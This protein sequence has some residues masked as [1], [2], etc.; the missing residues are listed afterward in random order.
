M[1]GSA[2]RNGGGAAERER[3]LDELALHN[4]R[5]LRDAIACGAH[6]G[7]QASLERLMTNLGDL[8][9]RARERVVLENDDHVFT[10]EDLLPICERLDA[11]FVHD[12]HHHRCNPDRLEVAETTELAAA[13][14]RPRS[15]SSTC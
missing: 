3:M 14:W 10:V 12:V 9:R 8:S 6:G 4:A 13:T 2:R 7:K 15:A 5:A 11:S 1:F